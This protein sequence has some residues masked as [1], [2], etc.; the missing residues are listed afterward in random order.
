MNYTL[1]TSVN[2]NTASSKLTQIVKEKATIPTIVTT[3]SI[4]SFINT[5]N[6]IIASIGVA[7]LLLIS[8]R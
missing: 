2:P 5:K 4:P 8:L 3:S 6:I 1:K 7:A